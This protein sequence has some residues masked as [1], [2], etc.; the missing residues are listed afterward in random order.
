VKLVVL[1]A[2][3]SSIKK[4]EGA[5]ST[6]NGLQEGHRKW[7]WGNQAEAAR[8]GEDRRPVLFFSDSALLLTG[9]LKGE[10][11][12]GRRGEATNRAQYLT[13][14]ATFSE[15]T[16]AFLEEIRQSRVV[17]AETLPGCL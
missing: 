9:C 2:T 11:I 14:W 5:R 6:P 4:G 17:A 3:N 10:G 13:A 1:E 16:R 12:C 15:K 8:G 7:L